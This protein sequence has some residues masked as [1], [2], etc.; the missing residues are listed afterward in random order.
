MWVKAS[1]KK[2]QDRQAPGP[3]NPSVCELVTGNMQECLG[4]DSL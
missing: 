4:V 3:K 1:W 2:S